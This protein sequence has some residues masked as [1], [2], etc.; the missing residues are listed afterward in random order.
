MSAEADPMQE[1]SDSEETVVVQHTNKSRKTIFAPCQTR[2][3]TRADPL[4][5][6]S[7]SAEAV[8]VQHTNKNLQKD[9]I[10]SLSPDCPHTC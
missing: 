1:H 10:C 6:N 8:A 7:D 5:E 3:S 9:K 4:Q 2:T